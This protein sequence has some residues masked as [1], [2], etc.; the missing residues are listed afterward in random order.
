MN[1]NQTIRAN[2]RQY[3]YDLLDKNY[4]MEYT[5]LK[6]G[7]NSKIEKLIKKASKDLTKIITQNIDQRTVVVKTFE[8][9]VQKKA[10]LDELKQLKVQ[11][12][13]EI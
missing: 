9:K 12:N 2:I 7:Q 1:K 6:G 8:D 5:E 3:L 4:G 11:I 10:R 13:S